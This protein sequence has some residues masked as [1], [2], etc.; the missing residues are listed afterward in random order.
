ML[1]NAKSS[2]LGNTNMRKSRTNGFRKNQGPPTATAS[3]E[4]DEQIVAASPS[5]SS[6]LGSSVMELNSQLS[7]PPSQTL[8]FKLLKAFNLQQYAK[9][10]IDHG[11]ADEIYKLTIM[12]K[13]QLTDLI[14]SL[15]LLPGH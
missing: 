12:N 10:F 11:I 7:K 1:K 3:P 9:S 2:N 14:S 6:S 4:M 13:R 5:T 15:K 8:I